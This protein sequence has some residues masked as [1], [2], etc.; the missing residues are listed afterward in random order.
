MRSLSILFAAICALSASAQQEADSLEAQPYY[1]LIGE[2]EEA[3]ADNRHEEA[4]ARLRDAMAVDPDNPGNVL[5]LSNLGVIYWRC[6]QDSMAL[7]VFDE[8]HRRAPSW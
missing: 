2:A 6:G 8:A 1:I 3:I 7:S 4:A 5:L